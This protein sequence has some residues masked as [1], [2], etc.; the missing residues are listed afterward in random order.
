MYSIVIRPVLKPKLSEVVTTTPTIGFN[1]ETVQY[2]N[3]ALTMWDF[4][5]QDRIRP[6]WKHLGYSVAPA[7]SPCSNEMGDRLEC[8]FSW[9]CYQNIGG[10]A[11][12]VAQ[13]LASMHAASYVV[14]LGNKK[15]TIYRKNGSLNCNLKWPTTGSKCTSEFQCRSIERFID[16][17]KSRHGA[18]ARYD[19]RGVPELPF[20]PRDAKQLELWMPQRQ[21][22]KLSVLPPSQSQGVQITRAPPV[23]LDPAHDGLGEDAGPGRPPPARTSPPNFVPKHGVPPKAADVLIHALQ[24]LGLLKATK[25]TPL[26]IRHSLLKVTLLLRAARSL[27]SA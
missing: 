20:P 2:K 22:S 23:T 7:A 25:A 26:V 27:T 24:I 21:S 4:G 5:A 10:S 18:D 9:S 8:P 11:E 17:I 6:L 1:V 13:H 12:N 16:H 15:R 14:F 3:I 19:A